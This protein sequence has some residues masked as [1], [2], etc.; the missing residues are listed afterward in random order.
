MSKLLV[1]S[2]LCFFF[3]SSK[4]A[5]WQENSKADTLVSTAVQN[6]RNDIDAI[7]K[8]K[9]LNNA[10]VGIFVQSTK[11][12]EL[13]YKRNE[14]KN[15]IPASTQKIITT[16]IALEN[17]GPDYTFSTNLYLRGII[18]SN[19]EFKGDLIIRGFGDPTLSFEFSQN[20]YQVFDKWIS[21][22]DS[23][24]IVSIRGNIIGD[25]NYFD[26]IAY[27]PGWAWDDL[28]EAYSSQIGALT[29]NYNYVDL[30]IEQGDS[31]NA[32]TKFRPKPETSYL[33]VVNNVLTGKSSETT[34]IDAYREPATNMVELNGLIK[35]DSTK[36][37]TEIKSIAIDNPTLFYLNIFKERL[38]KSNIKFR[39]ALLDIDDLNEKINYNSLQTLS[40]A[41]SLPLSEI[42]KKVN[43]NSN[44]TISEIIFKTLAK[45][46]TGNGT[47]RDARVFVKKYF[48]KVGL[49]SENIEIQDGSGLSRMNLISPFYQTQM[50]TLFSKSDNFSYLVNSLAKPGE[51]GTLKRRMLNTSA[52]GNVF[53]KTGSMENVST[54]CGYV[55]TKDKELIS[56]SILVNGFTVPQSVI[57]N[58]QDLIC[59]R[60]AAFTRKK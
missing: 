34:F 12:N 44:N 1:I 8:T 15:L 51:E 47:F 54:L 30:I 52:V 29:F 46:N 55:N 24:G 25:D 16:G 13:M 18:Q 32:K 11:N 57:R 43:K 9:E 49:S 21:E 23:L 3:I 37:S 60:L 45:E 41:E 20:P 22:L 53:A 36:K 4:L 7:L 48:D 17:L 38:T 50:L 56:F 27:P 26:D 6:L 2:F 14:L 31:V 28:E 33:R 35:F 39:G 40:E 42:I 19:G 59:M 10:N 58:I 5:A